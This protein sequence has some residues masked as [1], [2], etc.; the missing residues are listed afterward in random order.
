MGIAT[1]TMITVVSLHDRLANKV[2]LWVFQLCCVLVLVVSYVSGS[3]LNY[4]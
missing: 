1:S 4:H 2:L 3:A